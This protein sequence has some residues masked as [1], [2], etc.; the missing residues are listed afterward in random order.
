V[1]G[2][3][4]GLSAVASLQRDFLDP[5]PD[6]RAHWDIQQELRLTKLKSAPPIEYGGDLRHVRYRKHAR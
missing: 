6:A 3:G 4:R 5:P 1:L 2:R